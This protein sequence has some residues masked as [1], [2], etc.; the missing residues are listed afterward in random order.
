MAHFSG[1]AINT[2]SMELLP[3]ASSENLAQGSDNSS[4][5]EG[6]LAILNRLQF[7]A[8]KVEI[9][10]RKL[11]NTLHNVKGS[12]DSDLTENAANDYS[13]INSFQVNVLT[14]VSSE[15]NDNLD[16]ANICDDGSFSSAVMRETWENAETEQTTSF[17]II[18]VGSNKGHEI[19]TLQSEKQTLLAQEMDSELPECITRCQGENDVIEKALIPTINGNNRGTREFL[20]QLELFPREP[21]LPELA[22]SVKLASE[23]QNLKP[24]LLSTASIE[25][26]SCLPAPNVIELHTE[27]QSVSTYVSGTLGRS[28]DNLNMSSGPSAKHGRPAGEERQPLTY[29]YVVGLATARTST[30]SPQVTD[31]VAVHDEHCGPESR[32]SPLRGE[33]E[34]GISRS[35]VEFTPNTNRKFQYLQ[36]S[37]TEESGA[38]V[39]VKERDVRWEVSPAKHLSEHRSANK[40]L[41]ADLKLFK[42]RDMDEDFIDLSNVQEASS[43]E[44]PGWSLDANHNCILDS[45]ESMAT[46]DKEDEK[47]ICVAQNGAREGDLYAAERAE[48]VS[49]ETYRYKRS[50]NNYDPSNDRWI[51]MQMSS[52][53]TQRAGIVNH[54]PETRP[55]TEIRFTN[56]ES[57]EKFVNNQRMPA[58]YTGSSYVNNRRS[59]VTW[60]GNETQTTPDDSDGEDGVN[61]RRNT[62]PPRRRN[63]K[64]FGQVNSH[65]REHEETVEM[66]RKLSSG[67]SRSVPRKPLNSN[68]YTL[69]GPGEC[70]AHDRSLEQQLRDLIDPDTIGPAPANGKPLRPLLAHSTFTGSEVSGTLGFVRER[71]VHHLNSETLIKDPLV[72]W[73]PSSKASPAYPKRGSIDSSTDSPYSSLTSVSSTFDLGQS[74]DSTTFVLDCDYPPRNATSPRNSRPDERT[75]TSPSISYIST[76]YSSATEVGDTFRSFKLSTLASAQQ[77][78]ATLHQKLRGDLFCDNFRNMCGVSSPTS[79]LDTSELSMSDSVAECQ[80][81]YECECQTGI[82]SE[83][84]FIEELKTI[85]R[86][87]LNVRQK[88]S[89]S[90]KP[91]VRYFLDEEQ[92]DMD[93]FGSQLRENTNS[94]V[95]ILVKVILRLR[96]HFFGTIDSETPVSPPKSP[97]NSTTT[98]ASSEDTTQKPRRRISFSPSAMLLSAIGENSASE[99]KE[100]IEKEKLDVNQLSPSGRSLLHKASTAG[101]LE[102][103]HTLVQH[104]ARVNILDQ[105]GFPPLHS[106]LR[107]AHYK[108][109]IFLMECGTDLNSYTIGRVQEFM[110][111]TEIARTYPGTM[112]NTAL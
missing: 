14:G 51:D 35:T 6:D 41:K 16:G 24:S 81:Q 19:C 86:Y 39:E 105:D 82:P 5:T 53:A 4:L 71:D 66:R 46:L 87:V 9:L 99:V 74:A 63:N 42:Q 108:C 11:D 1:N 112:L 30:N 44:K 7:L 18:P 28:D 72:E 96:K 40:S 49:S 43:F 12:W 48:V 20:P 59:A 92:G 58:V 47:R 17:L 45:P 65:V 26:G 64:Q 76:D 70:T 88:A 27:E 110:D 90:K 15:R 54:A 77:V 29:G 101:D 52:T 93:L 10:E 102:S 106:A 62:S 21:S 80:C 83:E 34:R 13:V 61:T 94:A 33:P 31:E 89:A 57:A 67:T 60:N 97:P 78:P 100:V 8:E 98:K 32:I 55:Q 68:P 22:Q 37:R 3:R 85:S 73:G 50:Q 75:S 104:G 56:N 25:L 69:D 111:I 36:L 79:S 84:D 109:A 2:H 23:K 107:K 38:S 91:H 103:I 95:P